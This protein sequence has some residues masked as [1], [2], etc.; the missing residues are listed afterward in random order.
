M[1]TGEGKPL[2]R[3]LEMWMDCICSRSAADDEGVRFEVRLTATASLITFVFVEPRR[4]EVSRLGYHASSNCS[5]TTPAQLTKKNDDGKRHLDSRFARV[6]DTTITRRWA[7]IEWS[8]RIQ[9][10]LTG[11]QLPSEL[12]GGHGLRWHV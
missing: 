2:Q 3:P 7:G 10:I 6:I 4:R 12:C 9:R 11:Y 5:I 8:C 1:T